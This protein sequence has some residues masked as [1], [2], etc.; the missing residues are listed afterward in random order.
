M[1][2]LRPQQ[3]TIWLLRICLFVLIWYNEK[4]NFDCSKKHNIFATLTSCLVRKQV[5]KSTWSDNF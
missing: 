5:P 3:P 2:L 4:R 1:P